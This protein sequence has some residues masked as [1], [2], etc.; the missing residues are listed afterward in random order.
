[1]ATASAEWTGVIEI[2]GIEV[3]CRLFSAFGKPTPLPLILTHTPCHTNLGPVKDKP[4]KEENES[5]RL[6]KD[7]P[8]EAP[9]RQQFSCPKCGKTIPSDEV[10]HGVET[11]SG[12]IE[13]T[14]QVL[15]QLEFP[16]T[17][18][19]SAFLVKAD[20]PSLQAI[21]FGRRLYVLPK[22]G[23]QEHYVNA[24]YML[25]Q[26]GTLGFIPLFPLKK[27]ANIAVIRPLTIPAEFFGTERRIL[28][29]EMLNDS[30]CL[31]DPAYES[32]DFIGEM[33]SPNLADLAQ[34]V[35]RAQIGAINIRPEQ[36]INPKRARLK[37][38]IKTLVKASL[39]K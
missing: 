29:M 24:F 23:W 27:K 9:V 28:A 21:G 17:K 39:E 19:L 14:R 11:R 35:A 36:C 12:I 1:M 18:R 34:P 5:K 6:T 30:D 20:D 2:G 32:P 8:V 37:E 7:E 15:T 25:Q 38:L 22:P 16:A 13:L 33:P 3:D 26:S 4:K 31:K 10:G